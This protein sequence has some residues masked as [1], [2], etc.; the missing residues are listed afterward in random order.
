MVNSAVP[1]KQAKLLAVPEKQEKQLSKAQL[2]RKNRIYESKWDPYFQ[3]CLVIFF[4]ILSLLFIYPLWHVLVD[5]FSTPQY[6]ARPGFRLWTGG[7]TLDNYIHMFNTDSLWTGY[8]NTLLVVTGGW[9][10]SIVS[11]ILAAYPLSKPDLPLRKTI[12][13]F[14][15]LTMFI[16]GGLIPSYILINNT[17]GWRNN[18]LALIIPGGI[19]T[20]NIIIMRNFF[21]GLPKELEES[22]IM[23]GA[24]AFQILFRIVLPL[25]KPVIAT[26]SLWIIVGYWN[27]WFPGM[28]YLTEPNLFPL[29]VVLRRIIQ[30][31]SPQM[32]SLVEGFDTMLDTDMF[33][34]RATAIILS[35]VP[36]LCVYP[37]I[38]KHFTKGVLLGA[39]KG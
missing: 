13:T 2:R 8:R 1:G 28:L 37:F 16:S 26:I 4:V 9:A 39:V 27:S 10:F 15:I 33:T 29:Q 3:A 24:N 12:T 32:T 22:A 6:A 38:Q 18:M 36:I 19:S 25:S 20:T 14:F 34:L 17:L 30:T 35:V 23:D 31:D 21:M 5:S 11:T 7:F